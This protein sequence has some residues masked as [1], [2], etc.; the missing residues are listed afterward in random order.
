MN[1]R[2]A[3]LLVLSCAIGVTAAAQDNNGAQPPAQQSGGWQGQRGGRGMGGGFGA[4]R[5]VMGSVTEAAADHF[6]IKTETGDVY[7]VRFTSNT[8]IFKQGA[9]RGMGR[10]QGGGGAGQNQNGAQP[11]EPGQGYGGGQGGGGGFG[12]GNPP[13]Q[14]KPSDIKVGDAIRVVGNVDAS[15][16]S[17]AA[18]AIV[19]IDPQV[20]QQMAQ[21]QANFGKTWLQG[22]VTAIDGVKVTL[23]G[24]QDNAPHSFVAD[25]NT[26]FRKRRDPITLADVQVGDMVR[27]EGAVKDGVF[28]ASTVNAM[29]M[30]PEGAPNGPHGALPPA[31]PPQ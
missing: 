19:Q 10:G 17:I 11:D 23:T 20:A 26:T 1:L 12:R 4:G 18:M 14:L 16:K 6:T 30:P 5:G 3:C 15:A 7:T 25:E 13:Q 29:G 31:A 27:V 28:V 22:R 21:M 8:R 9:G 2:L 24:T